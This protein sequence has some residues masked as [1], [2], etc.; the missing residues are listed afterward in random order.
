MAD[1]VL[2]PERGVGL[3]D[4]S[5]SNV[6][7]PFG[8]HCRCHVGESDDNSGVHIL[9]WLLVHILSSS[10]RLGSIFWKIQNGKRAFVLILGRLRLGAIA[11]C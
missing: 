4:P 9:V 1:G 7:N 11:A 8:T 3:Y 2:G 6:E 5:L 10:I